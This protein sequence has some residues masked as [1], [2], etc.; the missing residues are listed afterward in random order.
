VHIAP[1]A[2]PSTWVHH[3]VPTFLP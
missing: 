3:L 1:M 2:A